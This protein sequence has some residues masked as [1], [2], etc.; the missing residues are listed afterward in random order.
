MV[1]IRVLLVAIDFTEVSSRVMSYACH[2]A[3]AWQA[4]LLVVHIVHD[5]SYFTGIYLTDTPLPELQQR[6]EAEAAERL[7]A[8]CHDELD[9]RVPYETLVVTGRPIAELHRLLRAHDV[10]CLVIGAHSTDKPEHQL[11]G[12][13]VERLLQH[14]ACPVFV[15]PPQRSSEIV[16]HG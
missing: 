9:A 13:T 14:A 10:D 5:L 15:I 12:S 11:F 1:N 16:S 6:L 3:A 7:E 2:L 4:R 8:F